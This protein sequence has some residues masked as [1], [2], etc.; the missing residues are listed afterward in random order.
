M[1]RRTFLRGAT[2]LGSGVFAGAAVAGCATSSPHNQG[3]GT[4]TSTTNHGPPDWS[5]LAASLSGTLLLPSD[6]GFTAAGHLYNSVYTQQAAAIAQCQSA[7]DVQRCLA[8]ARAAAVPVAARSG[9]HSYAAYSSCPGLVIDVTNLDTVSVGGGGLA[10]VGA[11]TILIDVYNQ[12]AAA[13]RLLPGGSCPTVGIA[14]L[15]LGGGIGVFARA[16][17]LT[18]DQLQSVE[19]VTAD[20]TMHRCGP[21][22]DEDLY[23]AC[24]GGGGGNFG[25]VTSFE[26]RTQPIP[27]AI[28]LF[29]LEWPWG[30]AG[31]VLNA[32]LPWIHSAPNELWA[33]C[34]LYSSGSVGS[35]L[36][37]VTGVFVGSPS[38]CSDAL[39][40]LTTAVGAGTTSR[41]VGPEEYLAATMIEAGCEGNTVAQ[42]AAPVQSPFVAK[43]SYIGGALSSSTVQTIT[44]ALSSFPSSLPGAGA[45]VVFDGYGGVI[46]QV[47]AGDTAFVHRSA[48]TCAQYSIT[49]AGAPPSQSQ[50]STAAEW[51]D[52]LQQA[53]APAS[54]GSYQNYIDPTLTNWQQAYYGSNLPRLQQVKRKYDPDQV[55]H[56]AQSIPA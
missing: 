40:P 31:D 37:K 35:G 45:G 4:S 47:G 42:C 48:V 16:Y 50:T 44:S 51:L 36:V 49:Y 24:R 3:G 33:N 9:G 14:G 41:F 55:F 54:Q 19:L 13:G 29:T 27:E 7:G 46:N 43:S 18:C 38:A 8:F 17:G 23:W 5:K 20:G 25:V 26:F 21:N 6:G 34:Q 30:A 15:A 12:L 53:F 11:G 10:T 22:Q 2:L 39:A 32:W 56:F 1:D 28:T 52:H